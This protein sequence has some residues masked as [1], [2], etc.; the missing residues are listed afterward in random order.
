MAGHRIITYIKEICELAKKNRSL[1]IQSVIF[2]GWEQMLDASAEANIQHAATKITNINT[3]IPR[4][5]LFSST[6][7]YS[8][9]DE[10]DGE[11]KRNTNSIPSQRLLSKRICQ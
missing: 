3:W 5:R 4:L 7:Y 6:N 9:L 11:D 1:R 10:F 2:V 8:I